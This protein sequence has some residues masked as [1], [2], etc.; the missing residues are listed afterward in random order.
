LSS[1]NRAK[2]NT[3]LY[4]WVSGQLFGDLMFK[5][6]KNVGSPPDSITG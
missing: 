2:Q 1:P 6:H 3:Q 4:Q 5:V